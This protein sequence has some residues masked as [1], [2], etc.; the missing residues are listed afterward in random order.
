MGLSQFHTKSPG[1]EENVHQGVYAGVHSR[2]PRKVAMETRERKRKKQKKIRGVE[3]TTRDRRVGEGPSLRPDPWLGPSCFL[4]GCGDEPKSMSGGLRRKTRYRIRRHPSG[5]QD[6][7][8]LPDE[9]F[10]KKTQNRQ[11]TCITFMTAEWN[12]FR[13]NRLHNGST[14]KRTL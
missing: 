2:T 13:E 12:I 10:G 7:Q 4:L 9:Y 1:G 6:E 11:F 14:I 5:R 3:R 8:Q